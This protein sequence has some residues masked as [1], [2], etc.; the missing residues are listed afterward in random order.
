MGKRNTA[1]RL[2]GITAIG[3]AGYHAVMGR[4]IIDTIEMSADDL[5]FV[6]ATYQI[7]TMGWL[8]GGVL[9]MGASRM[10]DQQARNWI[11]GVMTALYGLPAMGTLLLSGGK[12]NVGGVALALAVALAQYGRPRDLDPTPPL[13]TPERQLVG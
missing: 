6:G 5:A 13:V 1:L 7:G 4:R 12:P 3:T 2:A 9:L 8:A 11:V 10:A